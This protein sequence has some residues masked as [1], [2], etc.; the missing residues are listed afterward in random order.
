ME[1]TVNRQEA[2]R[3]LWFGVGSKAVAKRPASGILL[4][5]RETGRVL[6]AKRA[7]WM[8]DGGTWS[9]PGGVADPGEDL[10]EAAFR[11][12]AEEMGVLLTTSD[13]EFVTEYQT[14]NLR[15][16]YTVYVAIVD[17]EF[18][19]YVDEDETVDAEWFDVDEVL[20]PDFPLHPGLRPTLR[21]FR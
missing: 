7:K 17:E 14:W 18:P 16:S 1:T 9:T 15:R 21:D 13:C 12:F 10:V 4:V 20:E 11:E 5:C 8:A 19:V 6:L 2:A 3:M